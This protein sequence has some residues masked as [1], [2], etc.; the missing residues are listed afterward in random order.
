[1]KKIKLIISVFLVVLVSACNK[2]DEVN[3]NELIVGVWSSENVNINGIEGTDIN[4]WSG[5]SIAL[6]IKEGSEFYRNYLEGD[7]TLDKSKLTL[8]PNENI[9]SIEWNYEILELTES[10]LKLKIEL[11]EGDYCCDFDQFD[12][13]E[14]L[15]IIETYRK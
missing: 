9:Q 6:N 8:S 15:T 2:A 10:L 7:W 14:V 4:Q 3:F 12:E 5:P 1:M 13:D 11:T